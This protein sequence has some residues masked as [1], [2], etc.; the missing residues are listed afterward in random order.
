MREA[1]RRT[2]SAGT[3][4]AVLVARAG[5]AVARHA[6]RMLGGAYGRRVVV[7]CG[8]GNNG[9]DGRVAAARLRA[10]G[11]GVDELLLA[12]GVPEAALR[13]ALAR[14][15]LAID[16]MFGTGFRGALEGDAARVARMFAESRSEERRVGKECRSRGGP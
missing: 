8:G 11:V 6:L 12:D 13:R 10:R 14:A 4:E 3:P 1:D 15:H 9:A 2:I 16:A 7:V 5:G